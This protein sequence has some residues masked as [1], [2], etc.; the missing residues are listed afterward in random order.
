MK[1]QFDTTQDDVLVI[2][3]DEELDLDEASP[4]LT[5]LERKTGR[6]L[7]MVVVDCS[8]VTFLHTPGISRLVDLHV[9]L[10][11]RGGHLVICSLTQRIVDILKIVGLDRLLDVRHDLDSARAAMR[12]QPTV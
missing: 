6:D 8:R 1:S 12:K 3:A 9:R 2:E 4:L 11:K 5:Q 7:K 10:T